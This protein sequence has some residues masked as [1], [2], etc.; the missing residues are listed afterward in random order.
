MDIAEKL[1]TIAENEP[2]VYEAGFQAGR[3]AGGG[4]MTEEDVKEA[5]DNGYADGKEEGIAEGKV[6]GYNEGYDVGTADGKQA[7]Y[8]RFW[9]TFQQSGA[10]TGYA[11][12]F[13]GVGWTDNN[14]SP[15]YD[16][17]SNTGEGMFRNSAIENL[18]Q[19]LENNGVKLI[20][21][22]AS[23]YYFANTAK[24]KE[25]PELGSE[26]TNLE[27]SFS[28]SAVVG[29]EKLNLSTTASCR[30]TN[31]FRG[32]DDLKEIRFNDGA[33]PTSLNLQWSVNL[34]R[35]SLENVISSIADDHTTTITVSA[36]AVAAAFPDATEWDALCDTKP[37]LTVSE[38]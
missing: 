16:I 5:Y 1:A 18:V 19:I 2:K 15:K 4:G 9:D 10:R 31:A 8:D 12:A 32:C 34:S 24:V 20:V 22:S 17:T 7:E 37:N 6:E 26:I 11:Y 36:A 33:R 21:N 23:L 14:F 28:Y 3:L 38:V 25:F 13:Y 35:E 29:I 30:C 27:N